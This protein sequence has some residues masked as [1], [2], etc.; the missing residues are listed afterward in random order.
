MRALGF[1]VI[2]SFILAI[3]F[4]VV[5]SY[6]SLPVSTKMSARDSLWYSTTNWLLVKEDTTNFCSSW[7]F[8]IGAELDTISPV[9]HTHQKHSQGQAWQRFLNL[10]HGGEV[11]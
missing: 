2:V 4:N 11:I 7:L 6:P 5:F 9:P 10:R 8:M 3:G 1:N